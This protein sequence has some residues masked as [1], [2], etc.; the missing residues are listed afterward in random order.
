[1]ENIQTTRVTRLARGQD[2]DDSFVIDRYKKNN[3]WMFWGSFAGIERGPCVFWEREWGSMT[4]E[5]HS[6]HFPRIGNWIRERREETGHDYISLHDNASVHKGSP[7][8]EFLDANGVESM[9]WPANSSDLNPIENVW[10]MMKYYIQERY[11]EF[12]RMR[13]RKRAEIRPIVLE[14]WYHSITEEKLAQ[15]IGSMAKRCE[16][17]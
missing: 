8:R 1:M 4:S 17:V 13:Q 7:A 12:E 2:F 15:L 6:E 10:S 9:P 5:G 16:E 11:T 3:S 14:A